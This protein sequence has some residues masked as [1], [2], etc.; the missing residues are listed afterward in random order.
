VLLYLPLAGICVTWLFF[1]GLRL[2]VR[3]GGRLARLWRFLASLCLRV[4]PGDG[5]L[6]LWRWFRFIRRARFCRLRLLF[7]WLLLL[8]VL[9]GDRA[10]GQRERTAN[11]YGYNFFHVTLSSGLVRYLFE[12]LVGH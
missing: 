11:Q 4:L 1:G 9:L 5:L 12:F 2:G 10:R 7:L 8:F 3:F 6:W